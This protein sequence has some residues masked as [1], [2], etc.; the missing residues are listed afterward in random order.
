MAL[1][2]HTVKG[3]VVLPV[4]LILGLLAISCGG[5]DLLSVTVSN[6]DL[7][8]SQDFSLSADSVN[9]TTS[10]LGTV[11][12]EGDAAKPEER[13]VTIIASVEIDPRDWGGVGFYI[14]QAAWDVTNFTSDYPQGSPDPD[15]W[16]QLWTKAVD[17]RGFEK[18]IT[19]GKALYPDTSGGGTG[20][21]IIELAPF[22]GEDLPENFE[23][24]IGIGSKGDHILNP[25]D[26]DISVPVNRS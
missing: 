7:I 10:V 4:L 14:D 6:D 9:L 24:T 15:E 25:V 3:V 13:R 5:Q 17:P 12:V 18:M 8:A 1:N 11:F 20:N 23:M 22:P 19:I 21:V 26:E 2:R 16:A